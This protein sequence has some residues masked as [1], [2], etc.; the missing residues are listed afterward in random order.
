MQAEALGQLTPVRQDSAQ[1]RQANINKQKRNEQS[2]VVDETRRQRDGADTIRGKRGRHTKAIWG[3][4]SSNK[5][6]A[7]ERSDFCN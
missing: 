5:K 3:K 6:K 1:T 2:L 7:M 4:G